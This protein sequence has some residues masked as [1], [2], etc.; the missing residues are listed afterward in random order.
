MFIVHWSDV[1]NDVSDSK[2]QKFK[3][4]EDLVHFEYNLYILKQAKQKYIWMIIDVTISYKP[5]WTKRILE[6][7]PI[8]EI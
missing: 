1:F 5:F 7:Y 8:F 2:I 3:V 4:Q 6:K